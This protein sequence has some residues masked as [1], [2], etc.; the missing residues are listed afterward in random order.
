MKTVCK[1][2]WWP[3]NLLQVSDLTFV[4][5]SRSSEVIVLNQPY[6]SYILV[7]GLG[8]HIMSE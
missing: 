6:I 1:K 8:T 2:S 3:M 7:L 4:P 5:T